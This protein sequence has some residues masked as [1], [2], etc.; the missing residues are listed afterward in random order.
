[1]AGRY[2]ADFLLHLRQSPL[3]VKPPGLPPAEE[4]MGPP[5]E[6]FRTQ[7]K[8]ATTDRLKGGADGLL[9]NQENRRPALDRNGPSSRNVANPDDIIL[10]PPRTSF[11]SAT[12]MRNSRTSETEKGLKDSTERTDRFSFRTRVNDPEPVNDRF[13]DSR[14]N[15]FRRRG[16]QEQDSEGWSTVKP[17]K[18]FGHEGAERF[19]G[20]M[21]GGVGPDRFNPRGDGRVRD[22]EDRDAED[23]RMRVLDRPTRDKDAEDVDGLRRN[24]LTR[25]KSEPWFKDILGG[26]GGSGSTNNNSS[27]NNDAQISARERIEK[28]KSWRDRQP[29]DKQDNRHNE[30]TNDR[31]YERRWDREQRTEREPEWVEE[32]ADDRPSQGHTEEDF[33]KFMESMKASR[34]GGAS[35][36][37]EKTAMLLD[38]PAPEVPEP[39]L[40]VASAPAVES[41]PDK[42]FA[43]YGSIDASAAAAEAKEASR[44]KGGKSSR[45]MAFL[46]PTSQDDSRAK[47]EPPTPA[48]APPP[49]GSGNDAGPQS[50]ADKEAFALLI[51]KLQRSGLGSM[52]QSPSGLP[53]Q[54][55]FNKPSEPQTQPLPQTQT[56][57]QGPSLIQDLLDRQKSAVASPEPFQQYGGDRREDPRLRAQ[58]LGIHDIVSPRP[59][60]PPVQPPPVSRPE[61]ALHDLVAQR[62]QLPNQNNN[63]NNNNNG[64]NSNRTSQN[65]SAINSNTEFLMR[66]MQSHRDAPEPPR[67]EQLMVRMPQPNKQVTMPNMPDREPD[68]QRDRGMSQRQQQQHHQQ[69][70]QQLR[71]QIH[72]GFMDDQFHHPADVGVDSRPQPTQILQRPPPPGL[73]HHMHPFQMSSGVQQQPQQQQLPPQQRPMI[74]PPGLI[75]GPPRG[76]LPGLPPTMYPPNFPPGSF[77]PPEGLVGPGPPRSMQPPPGFYGG[78][79]PGFMPPPGMGVVGFQGPDGPVFGGLPPFDRRGMLPP[80][81][82]RGP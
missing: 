31:T 20:R 1:M 21:G 17:R 12:S 5:P 35:K 66:L 10:G 38:K 7:A 79:P 57:T 52:L 75:N 81:P 14:N 22:R 50:E 13:R 44:P 33:K 30:R 9:L 62:H 47:T 46:A 25:G 69:Q 39:D 16:D 11:A 70:Q 43:A 48:A 60:A 42:F 61:Q 19:H 2:S 74:P 36:S 15:T 63:N 72:P 78:P 27:A 4:W 6:T 40:K 80:G 73:D 65:V 3:C 67:T 29:D 18:S 58:Q 23:R 26:T 51:Q 37:D 41:G 64:N 71:G 49:T 55:P 76:N 34:A 8:T 24:G 68:Y 53:P 32:P 56:Q 28:A 59:M 45:F 77:P 54:Y 82:Y